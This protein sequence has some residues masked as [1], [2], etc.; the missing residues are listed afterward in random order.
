ML[1][2]D[3]L[4][5]AFHRLNEGRRHP[6]DEVASETWDLCAEEAGEAPPA[7]FLDGALDK[8]TAFSPWT[9]WEYEKPRVLGGQ[10]LHAATRAHLL[11]D[12]RINGAWIYCGSYKAEHGFGPEKLFGSGASDV[13]VLDRAHLLSNSP[14]SNFF[15]PFLRD[16]FPLALLPA[17]DEPS[18]VL[19]TKAYQHEAGYRTILDLPRPPRVRRARVGELIVYTD[20]AQN[21]S[22]LRRYTSLRQRLRA[23]LGAPGAGRADKIYLKRGATGERRMVRNEADLEAHLAGQGFDIVEPATLSAEAVS[24]RLLDARLV[25]SV[26]G[27]HLSHAIFSIADRGAF[28]VIQPP[29]RFATPHKEFADRIGMP[30][31]FLVGDPAEDG[32]TVDLEDL[33]RLLD[34]LP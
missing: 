23:G 13:E 6:V 20:F 2:V 30:F 15:G 26:E 16:D 12:A 17:P 21:G 10:I 9:S 29:D 33:D 22:K 5:W 19:E 14:G 24:R 27:S 18:I 34:K 1:N 7:I 4:V 25:V 28:L 3:K 11:R 31:A 32:F 8:I